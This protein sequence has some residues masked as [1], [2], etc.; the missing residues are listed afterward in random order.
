M[1]A[2][3]YAISGVLLAISG[4]LFMQDQF[5]A[6]HQTI[7]WA[8]IFFFASPAAGSAYLTVSEVFPVGFARL[9]SPSSMRL[10]QQSAGR[11]RHISWA[12]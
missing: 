4:W 6:T 1:I 5:N 9:P 3:T 10:G 8:L 2:F 7:A 12:A 11:A